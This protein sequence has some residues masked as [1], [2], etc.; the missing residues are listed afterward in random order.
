MEFNMETKDVQSHERSQ[1]SEKEKSFWNQYGPYII[2]GLM[3]LYVIILGIGTYAEL[4]DN[5]KI[6]DWLTFM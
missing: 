1:S 2:L 4:T 6:L 3:I 5:Q